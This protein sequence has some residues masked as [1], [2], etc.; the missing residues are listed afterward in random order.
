MKKAGEEAAGLIGIKA[1]EAAGEKAD[2]L[3]TSTSAPGQSNDLKRQLLT[4]VKA[5]VLK[6]RTLSNSCMK[7]VAQKAVT[8]YKWC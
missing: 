5:H 4:K 2:K 8:K 1:I 7:K 3:L 6:K